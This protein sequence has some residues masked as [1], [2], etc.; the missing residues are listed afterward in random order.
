MS[1]WRF[2]GELLKKAAG[3]SVAPAVETKP[4]SF[5]DVKPRAAQAGAQAEINVRA[6]LRALALGEGTSG[7]DGY[8]TL[9]GG[10]LFE[11]YRDHPANVGWKGYPLKDSLCVKAGFSPGCVSTAAGKYQFTRPTWNALRR[12]LDLHDFGPESQDRACLQLLEDCGAL[13]LIKVGRVKAAI[14]RARRNWASL[15]GAGYGQREENMDR[16]VAVYE[17]N[18][19]RLA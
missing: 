7:P 11:S 18:G 9:C 12:K 8:R 2:F 4:L 16:I 6:F 14:G 3:R 1:A 19:G 10:T 5:V 13:S 15:P 17:Q